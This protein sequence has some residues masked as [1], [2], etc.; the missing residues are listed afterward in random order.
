MKKLIYL[1]VIIS[2]V[3]S[4]RSDDEIENNGYEFI[5]EYSTTIP[6]SV[7]HRPFLLSKKLLIMIEASKLINS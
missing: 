5:A 7:T 4:C 1:L 6:R 2:G 3:F